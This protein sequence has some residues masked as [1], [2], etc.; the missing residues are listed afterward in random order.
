MTDRF[1]SK[2]VIYSGSMYLQW[3]CGRNP[4]G[5]GPQHEAGQAEDG[6]VYPQAYNLC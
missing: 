3:Y 1:Q 5:T 6:Q 4:Q 2:D